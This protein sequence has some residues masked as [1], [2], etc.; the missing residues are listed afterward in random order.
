MNFSA[1]A[2]TAPLSFFQGGE[3]IYVAR[4]IL[5]GKHRWCLDL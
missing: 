1:V 5:K 4:Q 2:I 3:R